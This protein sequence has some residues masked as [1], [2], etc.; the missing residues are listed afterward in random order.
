MARAQG[1]A[2]L[3][4]A[5]GTL[6]A[7]T[8]SDLMT[9]DDTPAFEHPLRS[10]NDVPRSDIRRV[11]GALA[12]SLDAMLATHAPT[13]DGDTTPG[14]EIDTPQKERVIDELTRCLGGPA[15]VTGI[16]VGDVVVRMSCHSE[17]EAAAVTAAVNH[18]GLA[19]KAAWF[20]G[21]DEHQ[22]VV[23]IIPTR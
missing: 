16:A 19:G 11:I 22:W 9:T 13:A 18:T 17:A 4:P 15:G 23:L 7:Q 14:F 8:K 3:G 1:E 6:A 12:E 21:G 2:R 20:K 10:R 5:R